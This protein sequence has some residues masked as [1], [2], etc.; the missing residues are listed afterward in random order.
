MKKLII[1]LALLCPLAAQAHTYSYSAKCGE[2]S[3]LAITHYGNEP[4]NVDTTVYQNNI[5]VLHYIDVN[6]EL[7]QMAYLPNGGMVDNFPLGAAVGSGDFIFMADTTTHANTAA[8]QLG[9]HK[10]SCSST[11]GKRIN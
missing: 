4:L 10:Y 3:V 9:N 6:D 7:T 8:L 2:Y 5:P 11:L 1:A